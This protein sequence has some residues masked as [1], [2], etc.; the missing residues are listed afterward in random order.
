MI[1]QSNGS[2]KQ[3]GVTT[4]ISNK[5]KSIRRDGEGRFILI[6]GKIHQDEVLILNI[7]AS[8]TRAPTYVQETLLKH[9]LHIKPHTLIVGN[10]NTPPN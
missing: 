7:Y 9:K 4:I 6:T 8:N 10:F 3:A 2:N 5:V 1:F